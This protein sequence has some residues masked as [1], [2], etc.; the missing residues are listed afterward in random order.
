M[1]GQANWNGRVPR[2]TEQAFG[3]GEYMQS[4]R[5]SNPDRPWHFVLAGLLAAMVALACGWN[6]L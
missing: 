4:D 6:P 1:K 5:Q 2:T 3:P